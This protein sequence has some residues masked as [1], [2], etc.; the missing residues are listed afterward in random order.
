MFN[1]FSKALQGRVDAPFIIAELSGNHN[2]S[3]DRVFRLIDAAV[4]AGASAVKIQTYRADTMTLDIDSGEFV[5]NDAN[6][7]WKGQSLYSLYSRAQTPW[8]WHQKIFDYAKER[9][10][11]CF[12]SPF[13]S[14]AVELLEELDAPAYKIA[15]FECI[16][17]P[18]IQKV[19]RTKKPLLIST[20][21]ASASEICLAVETAKANGCHSLGLL[22]CT[23][24]YPADPKNS[25]LKTIP[26]LK[27][28]CG[29]EVGLSDHTPGIGVAAAAV[30]LGATII[31]KHLTLSKDD[32]AVD[33][34]F[35]LD[36]NEFKEL[37]T[38]SRRAAAALGQISYGPSKDE[39]K[40]IGRRRSIYASQDLSPG[41]IITNSNIQCIRPGLGLEP[42]YYEI[43]CGMK[44]TRPVKR[45]TPLS[46]DLLKHEST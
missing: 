25:N 35:S 36:P 14:S 1:C 26:H 44:V 46:W 22:K 15:S 45:G 12:S 5:I 21:M 23:S 24:T 37:V 42:R 3:L 29:C 6:S 30:A 18:L 19:A 32:G 4:S 41:D 9:G 40:A 8:E 17:I 28:L 10:I 16:D 39:L 34:A 27:Q 13:D 31:E 2:G 7:L 33:S 43:V 20:G 38:E 11:T